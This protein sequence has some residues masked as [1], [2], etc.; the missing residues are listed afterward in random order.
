[1]LALQTIVARN[2]TGMSGASERADAAL[3]LLCASRNATIGHLYLCSDSELVLSASHGDVAGETLTAAASAVLEA[4]SERTEAISDMATG[5]LEDDSASTIVECSDVRY[6]LLLLSCLV[7]GKN[8]PV[9]VAAVAVGDQVPDA[10]KQA[11]LMQVL[12][13][14]LHVAATSEEMQK[15]R[16]QPDPSVT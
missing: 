13:A 8:T 6:E 11:Q 2:M 1:V 15:T 4:G 14:H 10:L 12:A 3:S 5:E 9:A 7:E 16:Q